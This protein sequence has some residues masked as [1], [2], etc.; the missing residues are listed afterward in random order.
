MAIGPK[1]KLAVIIAVSLFAAI[2]AVGVIIDIVSNFKGVVAIIS[3]AAGFVVM[4]G[5]IVTEMFISKINAA[6]NGEEEFSVEEDDED[7]ELEEPKKLSQKSLPEEKQFLR[8]SRFSRD[9][10]DSFGDMDADGELEHAAEET[11]DSE[12][13]PT[14]E[15]PEN[16]QPAEPPRRVFGGKFKRRDIEDQGISAAISSAQGIERPKTVPVEEQ[17]EE[18]SDIPEVMPV[19][20]FGSPKTP[21]TKADDGELD[22]FELELRG[23]Q[24]PDEATSQSAPEEQTVSQ[25][26]TQEQAEGS[27]TDTA[28]QA[29]AANEAQN[30]VSAQPEA[31]VQPV[32]NTQPAMQPQ[33]E[34]SAVQPVRQDGMVVASQS[35]GQSLDSFFEDMSEEDILYRDCVEVWA[36]DAKTPTLRLMKYLEAIDDKRTADLLGRECGYINAMLDRMVYFSQIDMIDQMLDMQEYN[37]SVLVKECLKRFSP[38]FMEKKIGLLWKGLDINV[39]TDKRWF[40]FALTQVIFNSVEF[41]PAGG[42]IAISAKKNDSFIDLAIEDSGEGIDP[43]ELPYIFVAGFMSDTAPNPHDRRTGMGLFIARSVL[44]KLGGDCLAES[45]KGKG[46]RIIMRLPAPKEAANTEN[47]G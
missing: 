4:A 34:V 11:D 13:L 36:A 7:D 22:D 5:V 24:Q 33:P 40:V 9:E 39:V 14:L 41:T 15:E 27:E 30:T 8:R 6:K 38:F 18:T 31:Q 45:T 43:E 23:E 17:P 32:T 2:S 47:N 37:F 46:T 42:K 21:E 44:G 10:E 25:N 35:P 3:I 29:P 19:L 16:E 12:P 20:S 1:K 26:P 28:I